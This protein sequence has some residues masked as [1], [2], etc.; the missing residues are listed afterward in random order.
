MNFNPHDS[1]TY[2]AF[3]RNASHRQILGI[4]LSGEIVGL[5]VLFLGVCAERIRLPM[6]LV[7]ILILAW[8]V[9][10]WLTFSRCPHCHAFLH[11]RL[12]DSRCPRCG[13]KLD[14]DPE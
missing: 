9:W 3:L 8:S 4:T 1:Q 2:P 6:F 11:I 10:F 14:D 13:K 5:C 7:G 12:R